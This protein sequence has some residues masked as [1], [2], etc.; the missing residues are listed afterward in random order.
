MKFELRPK[1]GRLIKDIPPGEH[2]TYRGEKYTRIQWRGEQS[3]T[4]A[5]VGNGC[6]LTTFLDHFREDSPT[7]VSAADMPVGTLFV[8]DSGCIGFAG[9]GSAYINGIPTLHETVSGT[10]LEAIKVD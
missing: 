5:V 1:R 8:T 6:Y 9:V 7:A 2:F 10:V 3:T 4:I